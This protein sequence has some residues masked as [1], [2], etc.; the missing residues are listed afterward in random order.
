MPSIG[1]SLEMALSS[2]CIE[3]PQTISKQHMVT[4]ND[5]TTYSQSAMRTVNVDVGEIAKALSMIQV[6]LKHSPLLFYV[7][8]LS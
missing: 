4:K 6:R 3:A 8:G 5:T 1:V 7:T 2:H